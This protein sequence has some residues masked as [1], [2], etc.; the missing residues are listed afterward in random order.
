[1]IFLRDGK[2][3]L[4]YIKTFNLINKISRKWLMNL[5]LKKGLK[6]NCSI[7]YH[8]KIVDINLNIK[9]SGRKHFTLI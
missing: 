6:L 3:I 1:M 2:E 8:E 7:K 9:I 5:F 4:F